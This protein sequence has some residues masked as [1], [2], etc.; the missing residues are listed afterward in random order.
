MVRKLL[1]AVVLMAI[2]TGCMDKKEL[3]EQ[4][5]VMAIG[6]DLYKGEKQNV[7][8]TF[9]IANPEVGST[10]AGGSTQEQA[11]ETVTLLANDFITAKNTANSFISRDITLDHTKV[12]IV[13]EELARSKDFIRIIQS[14]MRSRE[15]RRGVQIIVSKEKASDFLQNNKPALETRPHKYYQFMINR[16]KETGII[17][18]S[19]VHRF[20]QLTEGDADLFLAMYATTK[21]EGEKKMDGM[22]DRYIAGNVPQ[23]GGNQTQFIGSAVFKEG[24]MI[25]VINGEMTRLCL[26]LDNTL[27]IKDMLATY[28]DPVNEKYYVSTRVIKKKPTLV[29]LKYY[30]DRPTEIN[31][32]VAIDLEIVAVPSL[33]N[34]SLKE[35]REELRRSIRDGLNERF[36][37]FIKKTQEEYKG[38]PFYWSLYVR[39]YFLTVPAYEE[40]DWS[41]KIYPNAH[42]NV[43]F[44]IENIRY[45]KII[46]NSDLEKVRD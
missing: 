7:W 26:I 41:K 3:E 8:V 15:L 13:S 28:P 35:N 38:D 2:M 39:K 14:A 34:Y 36:N 32:S 21:V 4:A 27:N 5:Y 37:K 9:Q 31:V 16:A 19:T 12:L 17:P 11:K 1:W 23:K 25:D 22:E 45:G 33:V 6:L 30:K 29:D 46:R 44:D 18:E 24:Q 43:S 20:F 10:L 42:I 40:A